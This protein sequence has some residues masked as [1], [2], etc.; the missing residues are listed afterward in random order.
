[1]ALLD[2]SDPINAVEERLI[3]TILG[4]ASL[5]PDYENF[6]AVKGFPE[7]DVDV[8]LVKPLVAVYV[9]NNE[10][11]DTGYDNV[12]DTNGLSLSNPNWE[13]TS[14]VDCRLDLYVDVCCQKGT[15]SKPSLTGGA[16]VAKRIAGK[17]QTRL[18]L[19][20]ECL[21]EELELNRPISLQGPFEPTDSRGNP[22][23][24]YRVDV[25]LSFCVTEIL[26][27]VVLS[28]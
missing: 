4:F 5:D 21:G 10:T 16:T 15:V 6:S 7:I 1:M 12:V 28:Y 23:V 13:I 25:G 14:G 8:N 18:S 3:Q 9:Y 17:V 26:N 20:P 11:H 19:N 24:L 22:F 27:N 2:T